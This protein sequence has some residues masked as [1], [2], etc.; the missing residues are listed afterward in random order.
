MQVKLKFVTALFAGFLLVT[1]FSLYAQ[2]PDLSQNPGA[3]EDQPQNPP[4]LHSDDQ[5]QDQDVTTQP[6]SPNDREPMSEMPPKPSPN[7]MGPGPSDPN[8][9]NNNG[10]FNGG[11]AYPNGNGQSGNP[12]QAM[13]NN[14]V[15]RISLTHG[16]VSTQ[17]GDTGDWA[18]AQLNA[19]L[20]QGDRIS[21]GDKARTEIQLDYANVLRL[22]EHTQ[23]NITNL[24]RSQIQIQLGHGMANYTVLRNSDA[25]AEIDTPNVAIRTERR[26]SSFRILVTADDHTEVLVR[27]GEVEITTP[28]GG[29]RVGE[30][31]FITIRGTGDQTQYRIGEA[32]T[33]DDWDQWNTDRDRLIRDSA[34]RRRTNDYYVGSQDLDNYG[35]WQD[36]PD[37]G[38]VWVPSVGSDWAPYRAGRWVYEPYWGWTWVSYDPWGW[39]PYHYGRW[40]MYNNA[41]AW[42]PGPVYASPYYRPVWA[43][44]YVSFFG[45]GGGFGFGVGFGGGWGSIGWFPVGPCD[46]YH[47]WWGPYRGRFGYTGWNGYNRGGFAPLHGGNR[48]S[49]VRL[50]M[51]DEHFRGATS[52]AGN[53]FGRGTGHFQA[54]NHAMMQN[55]RFSTGNLPVMPNRESLAASGRPAAAS[56]LVNRGGNRFF[57]SRG[58]TSAANNR[59][60]GSF[61]REQSQLSN[62]MRQNGVSAI[63][64]NQRSFDNRGGSNQGFRNENNNRGD[65]NQAF[66]N[67]NNNFNRGDSNQGFRNNDNFNRGNSSMNNNGQTSRPGSN[68]GYRN[69]SPS[70]ENS[71]ATAD[72]RGNTMNTSPNREASPANNGGWQKFT[73][74]APRAEQPINRSPQGSM[75]NRG[76]A[77][78]GGA[79]RAP[80]YDNRSMP[81][82]GAS[83]APSYENRSMESRGYESRGYSNARPQLNMRQPIVAPRSY[84]NPY[85]GGYPGGSR[86][87]PSYGRSAPGYGGGRSAPS[88]GG[89]HSA[90]ASHGGGGSPH[91]GGSSHGGGGS[92]HG[93]GS[94]GGHR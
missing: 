56:T 9:S 18:A 50:A 59:S 45:F 19:P 94:H 51:H 6:Q 3:S 20:L 21:T 8:Y 29:T 66:R 47:P 30:N 26:E 75:E 39:A 28:Q 41:W 58:V 53:E 86:S 48:Y 7:V 77:Y 24:T 44:A 73:P 90:P 14:G 84:G 33:R 15:A 74:M 55:A 13:T 5:Y 43:P 83:R 54:V 93:G 2:N 72:I 63:N 64:G 10:D 17:R 89:G 36:V 61:Q 12:N 35:T 42:W 38:N 68:N 70:N 81:Y 69:F 79:S 52:V 40:F 25:D 4:V 46:Y 62:A 85:G 57:S 34:S 11:S 87:M 76:G 91:G 37:Y 65:A 80:S 49:N 1:P 71:R 60:F 31:Q 78:G 82:D 23:A 88:Y 67:N 27:R 16:D 32:P 22:A 92:S